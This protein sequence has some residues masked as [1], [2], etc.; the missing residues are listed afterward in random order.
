MKSYLT[1]FDPTF[2]SIFL[3]QNKSYEIFLVLLLVD[4][5]PEF[6]LGDGDL[7][8]WF[9]LI[10]DDSFDETDLRVEI[11]Y[12]ESFCRILFLTSF[13]S[14]FST[15]DGVNFLMKSSTC[16]YPPPYFD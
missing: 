8:R 4:A 3:F 9:R 14:T 7:P 6:T 1:L 13:R 15:S 2:V 11:R 10:G 12:K 5:R 16:I